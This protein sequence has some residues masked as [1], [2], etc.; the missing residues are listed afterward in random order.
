MVGVQKKARPVSTSRE[1]PPVTSWLLKRKRPAE[2]ALVL[3]TRIYEL[4]VE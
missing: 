3:Y 1:M 2:V 4:E